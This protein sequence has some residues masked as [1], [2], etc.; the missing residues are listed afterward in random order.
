MEKLKSE[1]DVEKRIAVDSSF[2]I[3]NN[4][5]FHEYFK[6]NL[7]NY[8]HFLCALVKTIDDK[9]QILNFLKNEN[10]FNK[11]YRTTD[12]FYK[13]FFELLLPEI[14]EINLKH[15]DSHVFQ[16][17]CMFTQKVRSTKIF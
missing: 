13:Y 8:F 2:Q 10:I 4:P 17:I 1:D 16:E 12:K 9:D 11:I 5:I 7:K 15:A 3:I 6:L 14:N